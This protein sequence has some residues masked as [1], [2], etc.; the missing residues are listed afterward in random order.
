MEKWK[1][2]MT[3]TTWPDAMSLIEARCQVRLWQGEGSI[4]RALLMAW[5][6][7]ADGMI[8][9]GDVQVDAELLA[10]ADKLRVIAQASAGVDNIDIG[11]CARKGIA[12]FNTPG[13]LV[14]ATADLTFGLVFNAARRIH[15]MW[16]IV[17]EGRWGSWKDVPMGQD[18]HGKTLGIVGMGSIGAAVAKRA[19]AFGMNIVYHNRKRREDE[20]SWHARYATLDQLL[21]QADFVVVLV[22]L[23]DQSRRMFG[24]AQFAAMKPSASFVNAS[25]GQLVDTDALYEALSHRTVAYAAL[26]VTDPEPIPAD[27]PLLSLPNLFITPHIGSA[28]TETRQRMANQAAEKLIAGLSGHFPPGRQETE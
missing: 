17:R 13:A 25:R 3:G 6:S 27:H 1:V 12:F 2:V 15:E 7:D 5:L 28:T 18:L 23:T 10:S 11:A 26:D 14:E 16:Q 19:H 24:Q 8:S 22:P 20:A 4:P 21:G 9:T